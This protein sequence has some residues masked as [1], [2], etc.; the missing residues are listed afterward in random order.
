[1]F[2]IGYF[3]E[4]GLRRKRCGLIGIDT[5][6]KWILLPSFPFP[7]LD[8]PAVVEVHVKIGRSGLLSKNMSWLRKPSVNTRGT[9]LRSE[10]EL[11]L[12]A[13]TCP[14][15]DL[16]LGFGSD[17]VWLVGAKEVGLRC[18]FQGRRMWPQA[19]GIRRPWGVG[20]LGR[21]QEMA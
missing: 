3:R 5:S 15:G 13:W 8:L 18:L 14:S 9:R 1:M 21:L 20:E 11:R 2:P 10:V 4:A 7:F 17:E 16:T 12:W 6:T 19:L